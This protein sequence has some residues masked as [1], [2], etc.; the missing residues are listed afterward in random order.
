MQPLFHPLT[1]Q[2]IASFL[3]HPSH[4][5]LIVG[6]AG[7]GKQYTIEYLAWRLLKMEPSDD[8]KNYPFFKA[9]LPEKDKA[10]IGIETIRELQ[11]FVKLKLPSN[12]RAWRIITIDGAHTMTAKA[13]NAL[14]KLLE[15]PPQQTI[16]LLT[17]DSLEGVLPTIRSRVQ[18]LSL[19]LPSLAATNSYFIAQG[20]DA[21]AVQQAAMVSGGLPGLTAALLQEKDHPLKQAVQTVKELLRATQFERLCRVDELAKKKPETLQVLFVLQ[22]MA[23][24]A[25]AQ[26]AQAAQH[27]SSSNTA[28]IH[29]RLSQWHRIQSAAYQAE[30]AYAVSA[31]A[32][33]TL[34]NLMLSL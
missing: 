3:S 6:P 8:L 32:K 2:H 9:V 10:S 14:L 1:E 31:Q 4:A 11:P 5:L 24:A 34:T 17:A 33:L 30:Q 18:Q 21:S 7:S 26:S 29:K 12:S 15:E 19:N 27:P 16:F 22:H 20:Y 28:D 13:Q 25:I 23:R